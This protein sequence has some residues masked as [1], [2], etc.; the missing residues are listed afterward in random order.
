M[1]NH[2]IDGDRLAELIQRCN[3]EVDEG[4]LPSCQLAIGFHG[5]IVV[6][7]TIGD[8]EPDTR[9]CFFSATKPFVAATVW[10]LLDEGLLELDTPIASLIPAFGNNG[11]ET[12]TLSQ[13]LLHTSGFPHAPMGP[14]VWSSSESRRSRM[15][16]WQLNWEP[17]TRY[18]Y[19]P[20][21]AHWVL[22][23]LITE[24]TG[25]PYSDE[26]HRRVTSPL[27]IP[28]ILG[29]SLDN[30]ESI[31]ELTLCEGEASP[32]ELESVFGV[33]E[34]PPSEV[35][36]ETIMR[37]ND[38]HTREVGVPGGGGYG[39]AADLAQFYQALLHNPD[40]IW[41]PALLADATGRVHNSLPD[42][43]GV[44]ANRGLGVILAGDDG[45][46]NR[47]G[48]GRTVSSMAFGHNG[49]GG[50]IAFCDPSTGLSFAYTTN[51]LDRHQIRQPRRGTSIASLAANCVSQE[52]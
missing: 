13:V 51:G 38:P 14:N 8:A 39:R 7:H 25:H 40:D 15:A 3:R 12:I 42:P 5:E 30:Q 29:L 20:T 21:S 32:D 46:S 27:G 33:R 22:A 47:R 50:Q 52:G 28:Q 43:M 17:G 19:H 11:K 23:E 31:A 44:P 37:F 48:L 10:Q 49:V 36:D 35:N 1:T 45:L 34:M 26:V 6:D 41:N 16:E 18:E 2:I 4:L 9:Y 24:V